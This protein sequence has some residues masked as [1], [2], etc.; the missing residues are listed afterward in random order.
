[1]ININQN[2]NFDVGLNNDNFTVCEGNNNNYTFLEK[3][4]LIDLDI[5][6][7]NLEN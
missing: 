1:M 5:L 6:D 4:L 2:L 7:I 3:I